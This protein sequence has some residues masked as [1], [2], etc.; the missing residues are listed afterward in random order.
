MSEVNP[1]ESSELANLI[2]SLKPQRLEEL[3]AL[4]RKPIFGEDYQFLTA[5]TGGRVINARTDDFGLIIKGKPNTSFH[6]DAFLIF[7]GTVPAAKLGADIITDA[8][9]GL[10]FSKAGHLVH[11]GFNQTFTSIIPSIQSFLDTHN[12]TGNVHCVGHSLGGAVATLAA[13]WISSN[14][15]NAVKLYTF[16][17]PKVG[18]TGFAKNLTDKIK[19]ENI[20]RVYHKTDPVPMIPI[21]PYVHAPYNVEGY[22]YP[23]TE[24]VALGKAHSMVKYVNN[25]RGQSWGTLSGLAK[26]P[27]D[28]D[29]DIERWIQ[30]EDNVTTKDAGFWHWVNSALA[31][32]IKK[33]IHGALILVQ[34]AII[35]LDTIVDRIAYILINSITVVVQGI[36]NLI[37]KLMKKIARALGI[38]KYDDVTQE[39]LTQNAMKDLLVKLSR[40]AHENASKALKDNESAV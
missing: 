20:Y 11:S 29:A 25:M 22:Y 24:F 1:Q 26:E 6:N 28:N 23:S 5:H 7:R 40:E 18:F 34:G 2:Y 16:G 33:A 14:R 38:T 9:I 10:D 36:G 31:Y 32:V 37:F 12:I 39:E 8:R 13:E 3:K 15:A 19:A 17:A 27:Y 30:A 35:G 4:V 21:Y